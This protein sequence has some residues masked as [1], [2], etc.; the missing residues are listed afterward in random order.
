[1]ANHMRALPL[2]VALQAKLFIGNY[3]IKL[4]IEDLESIVPWEFVNPSEDVPPPIRPD[5]PPKLF[6]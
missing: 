5:F 6:K 3:L 4:R 2:R 1:M